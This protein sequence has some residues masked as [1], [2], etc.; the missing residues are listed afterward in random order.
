MGSIP[1]AVW[2]GKT[3]YG[4]DVREHGSGNAGATNT[5]RVLGKAAGITVLSMDVLKG[6]LAIVLLAWFNPYEAESVAQVNFKLAIGVMAVVG[7]IFPI[8]AG[9][10][11]GKG[12]ATLLGVVIALHWQAALICIAIFLIIFLTTR[13]VSLG[14]MVTAISFPVMFF[15]FFRPVP[16][17]LIYFSMVIALLVLITHQK[18][19]ERLMR[20]EENRMN[21]RIRKKS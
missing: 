10:K 3:F 20:R 14:S 7:H 2:I 11:G 5:F 21:I 17:S 12:V 6:L 19:I 1:S 16:L 13:Y 4:I 8:F 15:L 9:F 18:N